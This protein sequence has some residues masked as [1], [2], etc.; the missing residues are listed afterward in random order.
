M[1]RIPDVID[2]WIDSGTAAWNCLYNDEKL[3]KEWFPADLILEA[4]EQT[5]LWFNMLQI[6]SAIMFGKSS[7]KNVYVHGMILDYQGTKM[8]KSLGN[9]ISPY[10]VVD[11]YSVDTLRYYICQKSAGE[12]INFSWE[13]VK[14]KQANLIILSNIANYINDLERQ[15]IAKGK[16]S[17]EDKWILSIYNSALLK[18]T[19]LFEKYRIDETIGEIEKLFIQLS[20]DYIKLVRER[21]NSN[22]AVLETLKEVYLGVLKMFSTICPF[23]SESLWQKMSQKEESIHLCDWP[24]PDEK[25]IDGKLEVEFSLALKT[26]E[27]GLAERDKVKIGLKWPLAKAIVFTKEKISEEL[28]EIIARQLNVKKIEMK[29]SEENRVELDVTMNLELEAEGFAREI[30]RHI[31]AARK[32]AGLVKTNKIELFLSC[33]VKMRRILEK[34]IGFLQ[35]RTNSENLRFAEGKIPSNAEKVKIKQEEICFFFS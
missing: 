29:K 17:I 19:K 22:S 23:I 12:N 2:V 35:E 21:A 5:K 28:Q 11:K 18:V 8:S 26:I 3:I 4:T 16:P 31:Q 14:S 20:K 1:K 6:C 24:K 15:K 34:N 30:A 10:E 33:S 13:D 7:Y 25:R 9:V 27:L 32:K